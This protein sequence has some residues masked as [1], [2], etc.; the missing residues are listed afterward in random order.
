MLR[1]TIWLGS[2]LTLLGLILTAIDLELYQS[3]AFIFIT[4]IGLL[5]ISIGTILKTDRRNNATNLEL[6]KRNN[7]IEVAKD[8]N[9][10]WPGIVSGESDETLSN[11]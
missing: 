1:F 11:N 2:I 4:Y 5:F 7:A 9:L 10:P 8:Y 3:V 6:V